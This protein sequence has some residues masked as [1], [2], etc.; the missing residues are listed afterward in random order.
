[1]EVCISIWAYGSIC[2]LLG[3]LM[4]IRLGKDAEKEEDSGAGGG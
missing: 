2:Y 3:M 1:M 4:G